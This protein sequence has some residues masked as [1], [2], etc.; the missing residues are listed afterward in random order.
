L[1]PHPERE[2]PARGRDHPGGTAREAGENGNRDEDGGEDEEEP[3]E[4]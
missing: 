3:A 1:F 4:R 2:N